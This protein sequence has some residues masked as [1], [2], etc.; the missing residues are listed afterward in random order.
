MEDID[1]FPTKEKQWADLEVE[2]SK[3][4]LRI[5]EG[6]SLGKATSHESNRP[7]KELLEILKKLCDQLTT[8]GYASSPKRGISTT[9]STSNKATSSKECSQ[10]IYRN[11]LLRLDRRT[12]SADAYFCLSSLLGC[13]DLVLQP[14][15]KALPLRTDMTLYQTPGEGTIHSTTTT[16]HPFGLFRKSDLT[17]HHKGGGSKRPWIRLIASVHERTNLTSGQSVRYCSVMVQQD[18]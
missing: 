5:N 9:A 6:P 16:R 8:K 1:S 3:S 17:N 12:A 18:K 4:H 13:M 7:N 10:D 15:K 2:I 11:L 14:P